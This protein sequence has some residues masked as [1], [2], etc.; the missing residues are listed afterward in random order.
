MLSR[1][2]FI[3]AIAVND[4]AAVVYQ[5]HEAMH[6]RRIA[7]ILYCLLQYIYDTEVSR[8]GS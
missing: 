3:V 5:I 7:T 2:L 4:V 8:R 6:V 1:Y